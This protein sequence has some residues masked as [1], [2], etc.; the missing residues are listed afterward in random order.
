M[1]SHVESERSKQS[2]GQGSASKDASKD[3]QGMEKTPKVGGNPVA[4]P[5]VNPSSADQ[6]ENGLR[7]K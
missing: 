6:K 7:G 4:N 5:P 2:S 3:P 1:P